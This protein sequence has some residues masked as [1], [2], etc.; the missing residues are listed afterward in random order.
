M[1][2]FRRIETLINHQ[3]YT[4]LQNGV[5]TTCKKNGKQNRSEHT[6]PREKESLVGR[7][8]KRQ[9]KTV[10]GHMA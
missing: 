2:T 3:I 7:P 8:L 5:V 9:H 4:N 6:G 1:M 10:E